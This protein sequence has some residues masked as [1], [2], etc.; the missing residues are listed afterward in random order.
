MDEAVPDSS[1]VAPPAPPPL[2]RLIGLACLFATVFV[3]ACGGGGGD[4]SPTPPPPAPLLGALTALTPVAPSPPSPPAP[5]PPP[6]SVSVSGTAEYQ[7]VPT[8]SNGGLNYAGQTLRP[9]RGATVQLIRTDTGAVLSTAQTDASGNYAFAPLASPNANVAVRVRA[10]LVSS[11]LGGP[12]TDITVRDNTSGDALYVL[13]SSP[14]LLG[15][16]SQV[17]SLQAA[18]GWGGSGYTQTRAAAPFAVLDTIYQ[19]VQKVRSA[20]P[21][22]SLPRLQVFWSPS[23]TPARGDLTLGQIGTSFFSSGANGARIYLLGAEN[24]DTDEY[25]SPVVAHEWGHY[26]Q[27][28]VSRDDSVGGSHTGNDRLDMRVAFSEGFGNAFAGM[29]LSNPRY[30]DSS[31]SGQTSG[32]VIDVSSNAFTNKG[33]YSEDSVQYLLWTWHQD[34]RIG[35]APIYAALTGPMRTSGALVGIHHFAQRLK[36]AQTGAASF[37]GSVL[38]GQSITAQDEWGAGETNTGSATGVLPLYKA[39]SNGAAQVCV[40]DA[41][42]EPNKLRNFAYLRFTTGA[43]RFVIRV[44]ANGATDTDPDVEVVAAN[45]L[46]FVA[47]SEVVSR[48]DFSVDLPAGTHSLVIEDFNLTSPNVSGERCFAVSIN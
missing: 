38:A 37:I 33:W 17:V 15:A 10:E 45:G 6:G 34:S 8:A 40:S 2:S 25:D 4:A 41:I 24:T 32:F 35:F 43:G 44:V 5:S 30:T 22:Q 27:T 42:G 48:E 7:S 13:Q 29:A 16:T 47:N 12:G 19:S 36:Q 14:V 31:R 21:T 11:L 20:V 1:A 28:A 3:A 23:N 39:V 46:Q 18:S 9:I 26:L